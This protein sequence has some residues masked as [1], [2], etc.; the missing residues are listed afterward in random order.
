MTG[1]CPVLCI[2]Y[3]RYDIA[4]KL[5]QAGRISSFPAATIRGGFG[6]T[7]RSLVCAASR[8]TACK[9][10]ILRQACVYARVFEPSPP[11]GA[12]R[13]ARV[14]NIPRPFIIS[15]RQDRESLSVQLTLF[16]SAVVCLPYFIY[17]FNKLGT[18]GIGK[19]HVKYAVE[20]IT[21][22]RGATVYPVDGANV[23]MDG[24]TQ[25]LKI[26]P[27]TPAQGSVT[28]RFGTP[29]VIR[30]N[31]AVAPTITSRTLIATLLRRATNLNAFYGAD[32]ALKIDP[33]PYLEAAA[34]LNVNTDM[35]PVRRSR[36]STRQQ[37]DIDYSGM[38]GEIALAGDVGTLMPLLKAGEVM[39]VGKN[40]VF[41]YGGYELHRG[42]MDASK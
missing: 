29:L 39:H 14:E 12:P 33:S 30:E 36:F 7:L 2:P 8:D 22:S 6:Y 27:G 24:P 35:R 9:A 5:Q 17:T 42:A 15:P 32:P 34:T 10:C 25:S 20:K 1:Q 18:R 21:D 11:P 38:I 16:G 19:D 31:G 28:L 23:R 4:L 13:L 37:K 41:G 3:E 40:T 26:A